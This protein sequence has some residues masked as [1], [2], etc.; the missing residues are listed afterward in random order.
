MIQWFDMSN[1]CA[2]CGSPASE[3]LFARNPVFGKPPT[4]GKW[5]LIG[6]YCELCIEGEKEYAKEYALEN[7]LE[8][9]IEPLSIGKEIK[10]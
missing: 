8:I 5:V 4:L 9:K 7:Q 1:S 2:T 10:R 3:K 6:V